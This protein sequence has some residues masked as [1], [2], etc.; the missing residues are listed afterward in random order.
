MNSLIF[1]TSCEKCPN[2][3]SGQ[4]PNMEQIC[5]FFPDDSDQATNHAHENS[6][7]L[8]FKCKE[9]PCKQIKLGPASCSY[10]QYLAGKAY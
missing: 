7:K 9:F 4:C 10:C 5:A 1:D 2:M 6:I 8:F 3:S